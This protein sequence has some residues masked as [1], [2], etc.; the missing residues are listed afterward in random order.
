M[1]GNLQT[2]GRKKES[3]WGIQRRD[4]LNKIVCDLIYELRVFLANKFYTQRIMSKFMYFSGLFN[5]WDARMHSA[6]T[7][8]RFNQVKSCRRCYNPPYIN[9][10][11]WSGVCNSGNEKQIESHQSSTEVIDSN[12]NVRWDSSWRCSDTTRPGKT[13]FS[14]VTPEKGDQGS[15]SIETSVKFL[16]TFVECSQIEI[17]MNLWIKSLEQTISRCNASLGII[18]NWNVTMLIRKLQKNFWKHYFDQS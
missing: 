15:Y 11:C 12:G 18:R 16:N 17:K 14:T 5:I 6:K 4:H 7:C 9:W 13:L 10:T 8:A 3:I 2:I 1:W